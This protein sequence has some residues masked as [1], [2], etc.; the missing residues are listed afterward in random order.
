MMQLELSPEERDELIQV[1]EAYLSDLRMEI[2]DTDSR[3]YKDGLKHEKSVL[4]ELLARLK[5]PPLSE[6]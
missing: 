6:T 2:V 5:A 4:A 3:T 1:L